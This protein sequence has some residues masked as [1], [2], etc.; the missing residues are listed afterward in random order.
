[1]TTPALA[2]TERLAEVWSA[3]MVEMSVQV[4]LLA[5]I[6]VFLAW[7]CRRRS[8]SFRY[9]LWMVVLVRLV[10]PPSMSLPTGWGWW[11][12][13]EAPIEIARVDAPEPIA[14]SEPPVV[15]LAP[16]E[17]LSAGDAVDATHIHDRA[18]T[19][20]EVPPSHA[21]AAPAAA[22]APTNPQ[23]LSAAAPPSWAAL[24]LLGWAGVSLTL[25]G[26]LVLGSLRTRQW[27]REASRELDPRLLR[28]LGRARWKL[29]FTRDVELRNSE[30]CTTPLVV[31]WRRPVILLPARVPHELDDDELEAV[32]LHELNHIL[33]HDALVNFAQA[34]LG[35]VYF[36]H[37]LVWLANYELRRLREDA[38]DEM[39]VAAL[40][41]RRHAYGS[42]LVKVSTILG[43]AA[44]PLALGVMESRHPAKR[45]LGRILDPNLPLTDRWSWLSL[46]LVAVLMIVFLPGGPRPATSSA[47]DASRRDIAVLPGEVLKRSLPRAGQQD[48]TPSLPASGRSAPADP[49]PLLRYRWRSGESL[50]YVIS[51]EAEDGTGIDTRQGSLTYTVR[52]A[53]K[54]RADLTAFGTLHGFRRPHPGLPFS[55]SRSPFDFASPFDQGPFGGFPQDR[56]LSIDDRG[57]I[58]SIRG[59][60]PLPYALGDLSRLALLPLSEKPQSEW[61]SSNQTR[62]ELE[63]QNSRYPPSRFLRPAPE[64]LEAQETNRYRL[65]AWNEE[66][67]TIE[68]QFELSTLQTIGAKPRLTMS[69]GGQAVFDR[70]LG[71]FR[72][73]E[74]QFTLVA[75]ESHVSRETYIKVSCQRMAP[76]PAESP[77]PVEV[78][79]PGL[80]L[81][82]ALRD[83]DSPD[84]EPLL[85]ALRLLQEAEPNQDRAATADRLAALTE[86]EEPEVREAAAAAFAQWSGPSDLDTLARMLQ[87]DSATVRT[88]ALKALGRLGASRSAEVVAARLLIP[89]DRVAAARALVDIGPASEKAVL[90]H[91]DHADL[92]VRLTAMNVLRDIGGEASLPPLR[93]LADRDP[94]ENIRTWASTALRAIEQR[95]GGEE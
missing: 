75:N 6:V 56:T 83:L 65:A 45:R 66:E 25:L 86:R 31:G 10:I 19:S 68:R 69:G 88:A 67:A 34:V 16:A 87:E 17:S 41:G 44:P 5:V 74:W 57:R 40:E 18:A 71:A 24:L 72:S 14:E 11:L 12:R 21:L 30:S 55:L 63:D 52:T 89:S 4:A 61:S 20:P 80:D 28:I 62:V 84:K 81:A 7:T 13:S 32:L 43:Y 76:Q 51:I 33:R 79:A 90:A 9:A 70:K 58:E 73:V 2:A 85:A 47:Q 78:A 35:A 60:S 39:T 53:E 1:M 23:E 48:E 94:Q 49:P 29:E 42:A 64:V 91:L 38:C 95:Q 50:M 27:V 59:S 54:E 37:P 82:Q 36:F 77:P 93:T 46:G 3:W 8:A 26:L 15:S 92:A 22:P